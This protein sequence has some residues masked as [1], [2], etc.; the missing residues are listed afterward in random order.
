VIV[1]SIL[2]ATYCYRSREET[3]VVGAIA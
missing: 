3:Q 2:L 1:P